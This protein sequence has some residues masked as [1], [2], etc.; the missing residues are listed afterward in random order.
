MNGTKR[1]LL[2]VLMVVTVIILLQQSQLGRSI[3]S[4]ILILLIVLTFVRNSGV[5]ANIVTPPQNTGS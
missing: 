5:I 1:I 4:Y 3:L 2:L